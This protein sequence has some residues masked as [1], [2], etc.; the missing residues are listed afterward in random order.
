MLEFFLSFNIEKNYFLE[1]KKRLASN[2]K[3]RSSA[4]EIKMLDDFK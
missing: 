3:M 4:K 2:C 1:K